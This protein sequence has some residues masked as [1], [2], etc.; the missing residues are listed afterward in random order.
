MSIRQDDQDLLIHELTHV[1]QG[2]D[3]LF[4]SAY[5]F[6]SLWHQRG[7]NAYDYGKDKPKPGEF[8]LQP[9][10]DYNPE[11]QAQLVEDWFHDGMKDN[12]E[13]NEPRYQYIVENLRKEYYAH[14]IRPLP[15]ATLD[16]KV[17]LP[18]IDPYLLPLLQTRYNA[19]DVAGYGGRFK[20]LQELFRRLYQP[21]AMA[22]YSRL[23]HRKV[24]DM[25]SMAFY[26]HLSSEG[27]AVLLGILKDQ[28]YFSR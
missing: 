13:G 9:W 16:V 1:W 14:P 8:E 21:V 11:Q 6:K 27:R 4:S 2:E 24:G 28:G 18:P 23:E 7:G 17:P 15:G 19:N 3:S 26:D 10:A 22:L 5:V 20:K 25:V 12:W